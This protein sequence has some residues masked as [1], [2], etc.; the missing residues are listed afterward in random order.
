MS[1]G[2]MNQCQCTESCRQ[3]SLK[4]EAFCKLHMQKCSR[5]SPLSGSEPDYEPKRWNTLNK[6]SDT[7][8]CFSY[9]MNVN[10][11]K[12]IKKCK[13]DV[14][15]DVPFHQPGLAAGYR[16][17]K[18]DKPKTCPNMIMR[19]LGDN[20]HISLTSF[21]KKCPPLTSK[22]ALV[23]DESDDYHFFRQ[24][25]NGFWS[26][27]PGARDVINVDAA[28]HTIWDPRLTYL[29]YR[30][31]GNDLNY[32]IFCSYMCVPRTK[33]LYLRSSGGSRK[34]TRRRKS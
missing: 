11:P 33:K 30:S 4:G 3:P 22:I 8:N 17:F 7:H 26:H 10:D 24:D 29:D 23:V 32:D 19:I 28:D 1:T 14:Y 13:S 25:S 9:A 20:P 16:G 31:K 2:K 27:K 12:Q 18:S 5:I 21:E 34:R 15:C 6:I